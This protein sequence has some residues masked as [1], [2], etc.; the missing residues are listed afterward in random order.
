MRANDV[1]HVLWTA[2]LKWQSDKVPRLGA[3]LA[4]YTVFSLAPLL[5]IAITIGGMFFGE[6]AA[7]GRVAVELRGMFGA[8]TADAIE[9]M[10]DHSARR[11]EQGAWAGLLGVVAL[12][13]GGSGVFG[14]LKDSLNTIWEVEPRPDL[15]WLWFFR[16]YVIS[17]AMVG[18]IGFLLLVSLVFSAVTSAASE[19]VAAYFEVP[20]RVL[21]LVDWTVTLGIITLLFAVIFKTLPDAIIAWRHVWLGAFVTAILFTIGKSLIGLY[22]GN[23]AVGSAYGAA[24]SLAI[25]MLWTY[26]SAQ[27]VLFGAELTVVY[28]RASGS[29]IVPAPHARKIPCPDPG[30]ASQIASRAQKEASP[31]S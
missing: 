16:D 26:Y 18:C 29:A 9:K 22:L 25:V 12:V 1:G 23:A 20:A 21:I 31:L 3:A 7:E 10:V 5:V 11:V 27:I 15:S 8:E 13:F 6:E 28:A 19:R 2:F 24:G 4:F 17:F 14:S 30:A